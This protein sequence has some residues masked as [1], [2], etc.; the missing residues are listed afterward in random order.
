[1]LTKNTAKFSVIVSMYR[2]CAYRYLCCCQM[3]LHVR[4]QSSLSSIN[5]LSM[6]LYLTCIPEAALHVHDGTVHDSVSGI[7]VPNVAIGIEKFCIRLCSST[8]PSLLK[9]TF[10]SS[11]RLHIQNIT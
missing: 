2:Y 5:S 10:I 11:L 3:R 4:R 1:M 9:L 7:I 6:N 8:R